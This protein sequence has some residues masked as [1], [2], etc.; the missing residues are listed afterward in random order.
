MPTT[1]RSPASR[2]SIFARPSAAPSLAPTSSRPAG[3]IAAR[4]RTF[5]KPA[6]SCARAAGQAQQI[7]ALRDAAATRPGPADPPARSAD[8]FAALAKRLLRHGLLERLA[9]RRHPQAA[10]RQRCRRCPAPPC[11]PGPTTKRIS[12]DFGRLSRVTMQRR[13]GDAAASAGAGIHQRLQIRIRRDCH[14]QIQAHF[15]DRAPR[16]T[17]LFLRREPVGARRHDDGVGVLAGSSRS[18]CSMPSF[19]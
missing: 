6:T 14:G 12:S 11:H 16:L 3:P 4:R 9:L 5:S 15:R 7:Q 18:P 8:C 17:R 2:A 19:S 13:S 1:G 10:A